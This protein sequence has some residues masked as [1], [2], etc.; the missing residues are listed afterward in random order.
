MTPFRSL[1]EKKVFNRNHIIEMLSATGENYELLLKKAYEVKQ[2]YI[3]NKVYFRGLVELSNIC[4]KNCYYCGIRH[5]NKKVKRYAVTD[6][7]VIECARYAHNRQWGSLVLQSGELNTP[8]FTNRIEKLLREIKKIGNGALGVTLSCGEQTE[9]VFRRWFEA[10][11]HRYLLRIES[12]TP[13]LYANIHPNDANHSYQNRI[14]TLKLL[15]KCGYQTGTGVMIGLPF[16]TIE[17]LADDLIFM[18][19]FDID[20]CGMGPYIEHEDTPLFAHR[21]KLPSLQQRLQLSF[22]MIACLRIIMK[23]INIASTTALQTI[24]P[25]GRENG[26]KAGSNII[27]PNITPVKY[28]DN[29]HLYKGKPAIPEETDE[30]LKGLEKQINDAGDEIAYG[31]WG[32]PL[33]FFARKNNT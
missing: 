33:H 20:M 16:Q 4:S 19:D 11:V 10:G 15:Q 12:A 26:L 22:K 8:A 21:D 28:H 9:E 25:K 27:M 30:Y 18:R 31:V 5:D 1:L 3:G 7:E 2:Q 24:D 23:D 14:D 32:D 6:D 29:Y 13:E 17:H